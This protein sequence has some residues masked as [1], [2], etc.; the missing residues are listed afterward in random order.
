[1]TTQTETN[2]Y[3][4]MAGLLEY[5]RE[6]IKD[7][8]KAFAG[9]LAGCTKYPPEVAEE[10]GKF[11]KDLDIIALDDLQGIYSY[12]FELTSDYSLDMGSH[13]FDGFK[14][15]N[16]LA[17]IKSMYRE[18]GFPYDQLAKGELP[19]HL[20]ILLHFLGFVK[21]PELMKD[22]RQGFVILALEKL[23]KNFEKNL[24]NIYRHLMSAVYRIIETDVKEVK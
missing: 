15:S 19:D 12:T 1:M 9:A 24:R 5:P 2:L 7:R 14:R 3:T 4:L 20:P 10:Y 17:V 6:D 13:I 18:T 21:D 8:A 16:K 22:F 23:H 11:M